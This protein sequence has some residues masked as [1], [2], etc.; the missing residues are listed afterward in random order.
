MMPDDETVADWMRL[1]RAEY[2]EIPGLR[3]SQAQAQRLWGLDPV[4]RGAL[5]DMLVDVKFLKRSHG[6]A[7][8]PRLRGCAT[9]TGGGAR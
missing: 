5:L 8:R 3:L 9:Q 4:L 7:C 2:L 6:Q 1:I